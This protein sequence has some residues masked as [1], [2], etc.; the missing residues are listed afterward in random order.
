MGWPSN[1]N[2]S[3]VQ[4]GAKFLEDLGWQSL[5][6]NISKLRAGRYMEYFGLAK[7]Y[8]ISNKM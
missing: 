8:T 2:Q 5:C 3:N 6:K 7:R 1:S 4:T